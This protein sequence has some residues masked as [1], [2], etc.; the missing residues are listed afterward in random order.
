MKYDVAILRDGSSISQLIYVSAP[1]A[2]MRD[3]TFV[4]LAERALERLS[5]MP[6][7]RK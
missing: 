6:D 4:A 2:V 5:R 1:G 3:T 7:Y